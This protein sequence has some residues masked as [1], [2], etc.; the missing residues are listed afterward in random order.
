MHPYI[1]KAVGITTKFLFLSNKYPR[2]S[3]NTYKHF[4]EK[5]AL[6]PL[7]AVTHGDAGEYFPF[8]VACS[9]DWWRLLGVH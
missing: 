1:G 9:K 5:S 8:Y 3:I 7:N 2:Y 4:D 6:L